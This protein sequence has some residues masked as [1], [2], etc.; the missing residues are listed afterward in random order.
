MATKPRK[1]VEVPQ[2]PECRSMHFGPWMIDQDWFTKAVDAVRAG[3]LRAGVPDE[4][5]PKT[6]PYQIAN[7]VAVVRMEGPVMKAKS[8]Y[9]G[10]SSVDMRAAVRKAADDEN[11]DAILL[12]IDSPG[13]TVAGTD[14]L[15]QDV[16]QANEHKPVYAHIEDLGASAAY[17]VASQCR[18]ITASRTSIIGSLGTMMVVV[19]SSDAADMQG[20]K[21]IPLTS[22]GMKGAGTGG[23]KITDE[24]LN[25]FQERVDDG[26][27]HFKTAV[28]SGRRFTKEKTD[29]LFDGRVHDAA[30][31]QELGLIDDVVSLDTAMQ[32]I[33]TEI[34]TMNQEAINTHLAEHPEAVAGYIEQGKKT[35]NTEG[36]NNERQRVLAILD[37]HG[38]KNHL[39]VD[40]IKSNHDAE[41]AQTIAKAASTAKA[42]AEATAKV[43][44]DK[45][46]ATIAAKDK[47]I[48]KLKFE[49]QGQKPLG[50]AAVATPV[51]TSDAKAQAKAA[52]DKLGDADK[53]QWLDEDTYARAFQ[54]GAVAA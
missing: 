39:A 31:A 51:A 8:K 24:Q 49:A 36:I 12:L 10:T 16:A 33:L 22:G 4:V 29:K 6:G 27:K 26:T 44:A 9:G 20:L 13:G 38:L 11:V 14:S 7:R 5:V 40:S 45:I 30:V 32:A 3:T 48:E 23:T 42:E 41:T 21:V 37:A 34:H 1:T 53:S 46:A 52:W 15:A 50:T 43:E 19:D 35:G 54:R 25:Y 18:R 28:Q 2:T 47:E 17:Y